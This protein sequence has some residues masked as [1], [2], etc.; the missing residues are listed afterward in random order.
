MEM[1]C[2]SFYI[3]NVIVYIRM[4]IY[5]HKINRCRRENNI[6]TFVHDRRDR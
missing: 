1:R 6:C 4:F 2:N 3:N 5:E